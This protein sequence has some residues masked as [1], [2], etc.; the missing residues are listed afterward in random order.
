MKRRGFA[1]RGPDA[2]SVTTALKIPNTFHQRRH[3]ERVC[4]TP[5]YLVTLVHVQCVYVLPVSHI[6]HSLAK[7][8]SLEERRAFK[9]KR[10]DGGPSPAC[11]DAPTDVRQPGPDNMSALHILTPPRP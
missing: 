4:L 2:A 8:A 11:F 6:L 10:C 9:D 1:L 5:W 7:R 3:V